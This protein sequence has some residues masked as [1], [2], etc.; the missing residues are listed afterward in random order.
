MLDLLGRL[1]TSS[2]LVVAAVHLMFLVQ[3][4]QAV[5]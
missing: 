2:L 5:C 1:N 3:A 4:V